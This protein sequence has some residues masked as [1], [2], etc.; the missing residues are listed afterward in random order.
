MFLYVHSYQRGRGSL[1]KANAWRFVER[2][3]VA[4]TRGRD[5]SSALLLFSGND[6]KRF[7]K[8]RVLRYGIVLCCACNSSF[9]VTVRHWKAFTS[10]SRLAIDERQINYERV[11]VNLLQCASIEK[12]IHFFPAHRVDYLRYTRNANTRNNN[13]AVV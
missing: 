5:D 10:E 9:A 8:R 1:L 7:Y 13:Q 2:D 11:L 4:G 12:K 3:K 6:N